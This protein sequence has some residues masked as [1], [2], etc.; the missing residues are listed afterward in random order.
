MGRAVSEALMAQALA[1]S[2]SGK[3]RLTAFLITDAGA[4]DFP[5]VYAAGVAAHLLING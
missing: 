3:Y 2:L 4:E 5:I 1:Q